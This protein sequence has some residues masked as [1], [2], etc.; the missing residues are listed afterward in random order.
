VLGVTEHPHFASDRYSIVAGIVWSVALT[1]LLLRLEPWKWTA[2]VGAS[3]AVAAGLLL[4]AMTWRQTPVWADSEALFKHSIKIVGES[5]HAAP[6]HYR[7]GYVYIRQQKQ[8][9]AA[10]HLEQAIR[11]EPG[12]VGAYRLLGDCWAELGDKNRG[13]VTYRRGLELSADDAVLRYK[14]ALLLAQT[15]QA[16]EASVEYER[17]LQI[18]RNRIPESLHAMYRD[19]LAAAK[20]GTSRH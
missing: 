19:A 20:S 7:L 12:L 14:L 13:I 11:L 3:A 1:G 9:A 5:R 17:L 4:G 10:E 18:H 16:E 8:R 2:R 15:G 6:F